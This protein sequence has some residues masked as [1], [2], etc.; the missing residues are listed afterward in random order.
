MNRERHLVADKT[1]GLKLVPLSMVDSGGINFVMNFF[2]NVLCDCVVIGI[3]DST[4][5][6]SR[7]VGQCDGNGKY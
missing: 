5:A 6:R 7:R 4:I 1:R 2:V 3:V